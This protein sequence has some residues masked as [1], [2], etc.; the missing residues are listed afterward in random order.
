MIA[1]PPDRCH[2]NV[3][4]LWKLYCLSPH[5][6]T[7]C[8]P[9]RGLGVVKG[10]IRLVR[11]FYTLTDTSQPVTTPNQPELRRLRGS[12][13]GVAR[14]LQKILNFNFT[15][16]LNLLCHE[17]RRQRIH[18]LRSSNQPTHCWCRCTLHH[19]GRYGPRHSRGSSS[20]PSVFVSQ[21]LN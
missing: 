6:Q 17:F 13:L 18:N 15:K 3:V 20:P 10:P 9:S 21:T 11:V 16:F 12:G 2:A 1:D 19:P 4:A 14:Q 8:K 7:S 5:S